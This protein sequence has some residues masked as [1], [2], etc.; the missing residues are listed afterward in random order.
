M[1]IVPEIVVYG[2]V[3]GIV[4]MGM[5]AFFFYIDFKKNAPEAFVLKAARK[6]KEKVPIAFLHFPDGTMRIALP[7]REKGRTGNPTS[8]PYY[9]I[10]GLGIKFR[11]LDGSKTEHLKD[12]SVIH[13]FPNIPEPISTQQAIAYSQLKDY[14]RERGIDITGIENVAF[15]IASDA[16]KLKDVERAIRNAQVTDEETRAK[17]VEFLRFIDENRKEIESLRLK[18][19]IFT[20]RTVVSA[21]DSVIAYTSANVA[22]TKA[23]IESWL[24][25]ELR[26]EITDWIKY[27]MFLFLAALGAGIFVMLAK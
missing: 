12:L 17:I 22:H 13:Y 20:Y 1:I 14:L 27:G 7:K 11:D 15:L 6:A 16:E 4:M 9:T 8:M 5:F 25:Q 23:V 18:S 26:S 2:L 24:R 21:L 10:P 3:L 19:G